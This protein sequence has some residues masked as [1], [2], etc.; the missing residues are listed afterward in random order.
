[1]SVTIEEIC[2]DI[3]ILNPETGKFEV[4]KA[5]RGEQIPS[6]IEGMRPKKPPKREGLHHFTPEELLSLRVPLVTHNGKV[7][8]YQRPFE[9]DH[10]RKVGVAMLEGRRFPEMQISIDGHGVMNCTDGQHRAVGGVISR[11]GFDGIV[12]RLTKEEQSQLFGDQ[13]RARPV[14][15]NVLIL[16][17]KGPYEEYIRA[18]LETKGH[19]WSTIVSMKGSKTR[20]TP[21]QMLRLLLFYVGNAANNTPSRPQIERWNSEAADE[22]APLISC[23][24][25]KQTNPL[26][27]ET[28]A[29]QAIGET[30][31]HVFQRN[32]Q[33]QAGDFDRWMAHMPKFPWERFRFLRTRTDYVGYLVQHWNKRLH[34]SRKVKL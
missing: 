16:A 33:V 21:Y 28:T 19:P 18:A 24:G 29:L 15:R 20:I 5:R 32:S 34:E 13:R 10:A 11:L 2:Q 14:D 4:G 12:K 27:F 6:I 7:L 8:G 22:L 1:M 17:A 30:A 25:D 26:A 31:M 23:F 3:P 9:R